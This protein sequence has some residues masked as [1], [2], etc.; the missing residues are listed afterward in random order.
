[1]S[2]DPLP[3]G[4]DANPL[5]KTWLRVHVQRLADQLAQVQAVQDRL[6][7]GYEHVVDQFN[8]ASISWTLQKQYTRQ[9]ARQQEVVQAI[10]EQYQIARDRL[11]VLED[12][13]I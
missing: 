7:Y 8:D 13:S 10:H 4:A 11:S 3:I 2:P 6:V 5:R 1:M 12:T 9:L